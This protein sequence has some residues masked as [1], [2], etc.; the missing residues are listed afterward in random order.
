MSLDILAQSEIT[1]TTIKDSFVVVPGDETS[2][3][4]KQILKNRVKRKTIRQAVILM[5]IDITKKKGDNEYVK[6]YQNTYHCQSK[7]YR[8]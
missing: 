2:V 8:F 6:Q 1:S 3:S 7:V 4:E 5:L